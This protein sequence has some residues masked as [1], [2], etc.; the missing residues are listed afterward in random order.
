MHGRIAVEFCDQRQQ[1][2]LLDIGRQHVLERRHAGALRLLVLAA[3]IHFT[4]GIV[5][6]QHHRESRRQAMLALQPRHLAGD[7]AAKLRGDEFSIDDPRRH[8]AK[9]P[10]DQNTLG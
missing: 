3:D 1:F 8:L 10:C 6:H 2:D 9:D 4:G 5:A 7:A